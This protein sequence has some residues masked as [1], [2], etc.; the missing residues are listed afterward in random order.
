ALSSLTGEPIRVALAGRTDAGVHAR[1]QVASL[2]T[3]SRHSK[4]TFVRGPN[5]QLPLDIAVRAARE[6]DLR[7]DPRRQAVSRR[8]RYSILLRPQRPALG[9]QVV[10]QVEQPVDLA[11]MAAAAELL[12]GRHDFAA[13]TQPSLAG[14]RRTERLVTSAALRRTR[15][16]AVFDIEANS[17]LPHMVRRIVAALVEVGLGKR[18]R[19][20]FER[21][22]R[23]APP[24]A[25]A[26]PAPA[27]GLCL[28]KVRYESGLFDDETDEDI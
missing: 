13:F 23:E 14:R 15:E 10:W 8:Y 21:L 4:G 24:G 1:G 18:S 20:E 9:R 27:R 3:A 22:V 16:L 26:V 11:A 7:F 12:V 28:V 19:A 25:A 2:A 6:V 5:A 17:F